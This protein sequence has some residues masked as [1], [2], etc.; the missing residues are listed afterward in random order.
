MVEWHRLKKSKKYQT[1]IKPAD[2]SAYGPAGFCWL[3]SKSKKQY[4]SDL[5][6]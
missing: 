5:L 1:N 6:E 4:L 2:P 3:K